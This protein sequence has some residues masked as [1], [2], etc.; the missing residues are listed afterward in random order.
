M[1][2]YFVAIPIYNGYLIIGY[3][4]IY[5]NLPVF[6]IV[7]DEDVPVSAALKFP[8]LYLTL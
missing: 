1:I 4:T 3:S 6:S 5:T 8:P 2:F 7:F